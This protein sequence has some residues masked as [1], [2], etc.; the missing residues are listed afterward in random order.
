MQTPN[1]HGVYE[2][3]SI[4]EIA[5]SGVASAVVW[6]CQCEDG[7]YRFSIELGYGI[8]GMSEPI[9]SQQTGFET[10]DAA[11]TAGIEELARRCPCCQPTHPYK[12]N[13]DI[14]QLAAL[15]RARLAQPSLLDLMV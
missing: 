9:S 13:Q 11:R 14:T 8:G 6:L 5:R 10:L 2:P 7:L 15:L 3:E 12:V 4:E 1:K